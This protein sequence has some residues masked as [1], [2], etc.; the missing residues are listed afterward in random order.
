[1]YHHTCY[2]VCLTLTS[3]VQTVS[4]G[5]KAAQVRTHQSFGS[6]CPF[7]SDI[8]IGKSKRSPRLGTSAEISFSRFEPS[9]PV[10][11]IEYESGRI[12]DSGLSVPTIIEESGMGSG[13]TFHGSALNSESELGEDHSFVDTEYLMRDKLAQARCLA[14]TRSRG[15]SRDEI[16]LADFSSKGGVMCCAMSL[17]GIFITKRNEQQ[18]P[19]SFLSTILVPFC[20]EY[21]ILSDDVLLSYIEARCKE[22]DI[23]YCMVEQIALVAQCCHDPVN[24]ARGVLQVLNSAYVCNC[25]F[26]WLEDLTKDSIR[27]SFSDSKLSA[28]LQESSRLFRID[29]I[30][31]KYCG[32]EARE[33]FRIDNPKHAIR[34]AKFVSQNSK[35]QNVIDD[36]LTLCE[37]FVHLSI[38]ELCTNLIQN[39]LRD[40]SESSSSLFGLLLSKDRAIAQMV[41]V[42]L[43]AFVEETLQENSIFLNRNCS[44]C[45]RKSD[46]IANIIARFQAILCAMIQA[47][48]ISPEVLNN[49]ECLSGVTSYENLKR[50][51]DLVSELFRNSEIIVSLSELSRPKCLLD[52]VKL[53]VGSSML[54]CDSE[55]SH[56]QKVASL[57][58]DYGSLKDGIHS[59]ALLCVCV[60][61]LLETKSGSIVELLRQSDMNTIS[62]S[63]PF[64]NVCLKLASSCVEK[65]MGSTLPVEELSRLLGLSNVLVQDFALPKSSDRTIGRIQTIFSFFNISMRTLA[66]VEQSFSSQHEK[67]TTTESTILNGGLTSH[68]PKLHTSWYI[69]D[70]LLMPS[71]ESLSF[72]LDIC[73]ETL[74]CDKSPFDA[75]QDL[76]YLARDHGA[77]G[78]C[79]QIL[80]SCSTLSTLPDPESLQYALSDA[81]TNIV[82]RSIGGTTSGIMSHVVDAQLTLA[83]LP[84]LS[85]HSSDRL[86]KSPLPTA[87]K[88][89]SYKRLLSIAN[90]GQLAHHA[91]DNDAY[92]PL[93]KSPWLPDIGPGFYHLT[94]HGMWWSYMHGIT[95]SFQ[96]TTPFHSEKNI[97]GELS[98]WLGVHAANDGDATKDFVGFLRENRNVHRE[99]DLHEAFQLGLRFAADFGI[100]FDQI[101]Q[102]FIELLLFDNNKHGNL[103]ETTATVKSLLRGVRPAKKKVSLLRKCVL[104]I[105]ATAKYDMDYE[106]HF[107]VLTLYRDALLQILD[108]DSTSQV[109]DSA[110]YESELEMVDRRRD[111]LEILSAYF[112]KDTDRVSFP[113]MFARLPEAM[114][115]TTELI[116]QHNHVLGR[117]R[118]GTEASLDPLKPLEPLF[119]DATKLSSISALAPICFSLG[120]PTGYVHARALMARFAGSKS[121]SELPSFLHDVLPTIEKLRQNS[122]KSHLAEWCAGYYGVG[123]E[124]ERLRCLEIALDTAVSSSI[125]LENGKEK[126][127]NMKTDLD[128]ALERIKSLERSKSSLADQ[129][130]VKAALQVGEDSLSETRQLIVQ[131]VNALAEKWE[132]INDD[133]T[134]EELVYTI[135]SSSAFLV[136]KGALERSSAFSVSHIRGISKLVSKACSVLSDHYSHIHTESFVQEL[137]RELLFY[138]NLKRCQKLVADNGLHSLS[139]FTWDQPCNAEPSI[140]SLSERETAEYCYQSA[141]I[142]IA[143]LFSLIDRKEAPERNSKP[144]RPVGGD[145]TNKTLPRRR[146]RLLQKLDTLRENPKRSLAFEHARVLLQ[147]VFSKSSITSNLLT[148]TETPSNGDSPEEKIN[149]GP[150]TFAMRY[151]AFRAA[152]VL[153][154]QSVLEQV[155]QDESLVNFALKPNDTPLRLCTFGSFVAKEIEDLGLQVPHSDLGQLSS[156]HYPSYART[157]WKNTKESGT[158]YGARFLLLLLDM[159]LKGSLS[160]SDQSFVDA[161][162]RELQ[163]GNYH[164]SLLLGVESCL[165]RGCDLD[166]SFLQALVDGST[167]AVSLQQPGSNEASSS[168][169][170]VEKAL[171][172][173]GAIDCLEQIQAIQSDCSTRS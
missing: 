4:G 30:V 124:N 141:S 161:I 172:D 147:I 115:S 78:L 93:L 122:D 154:P 153:C 2:L 59:Y 16:T 102:S 27:W 123:R 60:E 129:I 50:R 29:S 125:E 143:F 164:R 107:L 169:R 22:H 17:V 92:S 104:K 99:F 62:E 42:G 75:C 118:E 54:V 81:C 48:C 144:S 64:S 103:I 36:I 49:I 70:G 136:A 65:T 84:Y 132:N 173:S 106:S 32:N 68:A 126:T 117:F 7:T 31:R 120:L 100:P 26:P 149:S 88:T 37:A 166:R 9:E 51:L 121:L 156:M 80:L 46:M 20:E 53:M 23:D 148:F 128:L 133:Q 82:E 152:S 110:M 116:P 87:I 158:P 111:T 72:V 73:Q 171:I 142:Q 89:R 151:R 28:E 94:R 114:G 145:K 127:S 3:G 5:L 96:A 15:V 10:S 69:G 76:V 112:N 113:S 71:R 12:P 11:S 67:C 150:V 131:L 25:D 13:A 162:L 160:P 108:H 63:I 8:R 119:R 55:D 98:E 43:L 139:P 74:A 105:E 130:A 146:G 91:A 159:V 85:V 101:H 168:F 57:F 24:K 140:E 39:A 157:L 44:A 45:P 134:P 95:C 47:N 137:V 83:L 66:Q 155:V 77:H 165:E 79:S 35:E 52:V 90:V 38:P 135:L 167:T 163:Q 138:G 1:M 61:L 34:L 19:D 18:L 170:R 14:D 41:F 56:V 86:L 58:S 21:G 6:F 97:A 33:L 109:A 40:S